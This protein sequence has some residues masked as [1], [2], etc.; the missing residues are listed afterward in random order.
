[1]T[2]SMHSEPAFTDCGFDNYEKALGKFAQH[3]ASMSHREAVMKCSAIRGPS[4]ESILAAQLQKQQ[5]VNRVELLKQL[6]AM[7]FLLW[8][9]LALRGHHHVEGNLYQLLR[10]WSDDSDVIWSWL[11]QNT[12]LSHDHVNEMIML[13][14]HYVLRTIIFHV[15]SCTPAFF[16]HC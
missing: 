3:E 2:F 7:K 9:S 16:H 13:M 8:Q 6:A 12:F 15:R 10:T 4:I 1:M 5:E 14:G 11:K